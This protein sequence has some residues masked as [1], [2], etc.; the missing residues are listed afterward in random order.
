MSHGPAGHA[1]GGAHGEHGHGAAVAEPGA[2]EAHGHAEL[3]PEPAERHITPAPED[4]RNLPGPSA[5]FWPFLWMG[6]A[7]LLIAVL[8]KAGWPP[9][10]DEH[11]HATPAPHGTPSR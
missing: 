1:A 6:L 3:P 11:G 8:L 10:A 9:F 4:F 5:L 7:V 2:H